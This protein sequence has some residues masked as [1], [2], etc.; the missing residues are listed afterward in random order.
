MADKTEDAN[1]QSKG[2]FQDQIRDAVKNAGDAADDDQA[3]D[4]GVNDADKGGSDA[5]AGKSTTGDDSNDDDSA[6]DSD[7]DSDQDDDDSD[8]DAGAGKGDDKSEVKLPQ[9]KGDGK[10]GSYTK[11]IESAYI[12]QAQKL[13]ELNDRAESFERQVTA[14]RN[15]AAK[16]P[17]FGTKLL[18]LLDVDGD[19]GSG[20]SSAGSDRGGSTT[21]DANEDPF[22]THAKTEWKEKNNANTKEFVDNN[23]EVLT[24]PELN[25]KV[26]GLMKEFS[27][28]ELAKN[29]RLMMGGEAMEKAYRYLGLDVKRKNDQALADGMKGD[30]APARPRRAKKPAKSGGTKQFSDLT[31]S[32]ASKMGMSKERLV[33]GTGKS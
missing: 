2:S 17:E 5:E 8:D 29:G 31:L 1:D 14:I 18:S 27:N 3:D 4:D 7:N 19:G 25:K 33:K 10:R 22:L 24:D 9:F 11:N 12:D 20:G 15:A 23:P 28:M 30:G 32:L 13:N 6:D 16:D 26:K 21:D